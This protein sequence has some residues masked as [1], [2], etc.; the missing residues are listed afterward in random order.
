LVKP[1]YFNLNAGLKISLGKSKETTTQNVNRNLPICDISLVEL[2]CDS[3]GS[4]LK[5]MQFWNNFDP[6]FK[7]TVEVFNGTTLINPT[8]SSPQFLSQNYGNIP[9]YTGIN[10]NLIGAS[11]SAIMKIFDTNGNMVCSKNIS[12]TVPQCSPQPLSCDFAIDLE[13]AICD[14]TTITYNAIG[15]WAN[16]NPGSIIDLEAKDQSGSPITITVVPAFPITITAANST[17]N[18][19]NTISIPAS[20][21]GSQISITMKITEPT[22][23]FVKTCGFLDVFTPVCEPQTSD[24][25]WEYTVSCD[26]KNNGIKIN[27]TSIW[28]NMPVGSNLN[29]SLISQ[30]GGSPIPFTF[31]PNNLPQTIG[32]NGTS[33]HTL[34]INS[35]YSNTPVVF[36]MEI[37]D[38]NGALICNKGKDFIL[39]S[40][41][42][43]ICELI[44]NN[45]YCQDGTN[46]INFTFNWANYSNFSNY[47]IYAEIT[48][49]S[50][51]NIVTYPLIPLGSAS[52]SIAKSQIIPSQYAGSTIYVKIKIC[53]TAN[54]G[55]KNCCLSFIKIDIPKCCINCFDIDLESADINPNIVAN[56]FPV[57]GW[58]NSKP[59]KKL[60]FQLEYF[61]CND[62]NGAPII[63]PDNFEFSKNSVINGSAVNLIGSLTGD[64]SN[65]IVKSFP[66]STTG[67]NFNLLIDNYTNKRVVNFRIKLTTFFMDGTYC[68]SYLSK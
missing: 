24:C 56:D 13:N 25:N 49:T 66:P 9:F 58:F 23:G 60:I 35:S 5:L 21:N 39:P 40:C 27:V 14:G 33:S 62:L 31:L 4:T 32:G 43:K 29:Y 6:T 34:F 22:T 42:F 19:S 1:S 8:T 51:N 37:D 17:G 57:N 44:E 16:L 54:G 41:I 38:G 48:D 68:E 59:V 20:Y 46:I 65:M 30:N 53:E 64:R 63:I 26:P 55:N 47:S 11:F 61:N 15:S 2:E 3:L 10:S 50:N 7:R 12:F 52:G 28:N 67:V 45:S 36:K 18:T